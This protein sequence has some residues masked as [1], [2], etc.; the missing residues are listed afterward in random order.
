MHARCIY[1]IICTHTQTRKMVEMAHAPN[2]DRGD[3]NL[4]TKAVHQRLR[5]I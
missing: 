1:Y 2:T 5:C 4:Q 3:Q